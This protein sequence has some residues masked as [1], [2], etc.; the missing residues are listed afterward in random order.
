MV[1]KKDII[2]TGDFND[3]IGNKYDEVTQIIESLGLV[4]I[5]C[6]RHGFESDVRTYNRGSEHILFEILNEWSQNPSY[7]L[8]RLAKLT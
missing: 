5:Y 8:S 2:L 7:Q 3:E 6:Y 4:D 1:D